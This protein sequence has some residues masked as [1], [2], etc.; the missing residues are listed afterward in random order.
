MNLYVVHPSG[1]QDINIRL[2]H[3]L[4]LMKLSILDDKCEKRALSFFI[5]F[6]VGSLETFK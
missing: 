3:F 1:L 2:L 5:R 4:M 6:P